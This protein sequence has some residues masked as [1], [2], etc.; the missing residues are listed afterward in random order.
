VGEDVMDEEFKDVTDPL[1]LSGGVLSDTF[2]QSDNSWTDLA[3][4][5]FTFMDTGT[6]KVFL[7]VGFDPPTVEVDPDLDWNTAAKMFWNAVYRM[8]GKSPLFP[9]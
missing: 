2:V 7:T 1:P 6:D 9:D 3:P 8:V 5:R 4:D